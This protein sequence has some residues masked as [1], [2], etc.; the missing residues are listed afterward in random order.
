MNYSLIYDN[1]VAR[2]RGRKRAKLV[3]Y[4]R[5]HIKPR[6]MGGNDHR[7]N[8]IYLTLREHF[9]AHMLLCKIYPTEHKLAS[10]AFL[11]KGKTSG[12]MSSKTYDKLKISAIIAGKSREPYK[13]TLEQ[14]TKISVALKK[15][16]SDPEVR[17]AHSARMKQRR[18]GPMSAEHRAKLSKAQ[19]LRRSPPEQTWQ[20][21]YA[22][23]P[24]VED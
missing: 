8:L 13:L 11:M 9:I 15:H 1:L 7:G 24:P 18:P 14:R 2:A 4:E 21:W 12:Y 5:H 10:A 22:S 19:L 17:A 20:E 16:M 6:C 23:L 3:Q